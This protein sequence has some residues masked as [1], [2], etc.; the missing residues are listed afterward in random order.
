MAARARPRMGDIGKASAVWGALPSVAHTVLGVGFAAM[1]FLSAV[2][3]QIVLVG[4]AAL[5]L[6]VVTFVLVNLALRE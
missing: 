5:V 4:L 6:L 1:D 2:T 3:P